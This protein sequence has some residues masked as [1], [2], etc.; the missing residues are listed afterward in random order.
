MVSVE[1]AS[2]IILRQVSPLPGE[3]VALLQATGRVLFENVRAS[4]NVPPFAN[5]AM[6]GYA[7]RWLDVARASATD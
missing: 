3:G 2:R 1:E 4:R 7:V 5:S 6:D